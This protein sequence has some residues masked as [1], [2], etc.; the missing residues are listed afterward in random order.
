MIVI[1]GPDGAGKSTLAEAIADDFELAIRHTG[2]PGP[3]KRHQTYN[4]LAAAVSGLGDPIVYDRFMMSES[5]YGR[6]LRK[7]VGSQFSAYEEGYV[8]RVLDA[9][10]CPVIL[11]LPPL[12][13]CLHN[14]EMDREAGDD[15]A[16]VRKQLPDI[17]KAYENTLKI[18]PWTNIYDYTRKGMEDIMMSRVEEYLQQRRARE[19]NSENSSVST[20]SG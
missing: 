12:D 14:F 2:G 1:E 19:W 17:W 4:R 13:V 8:L 10:D 5:I 20:S 9:L 3:D 6:L 11:C 16:N 18:G 7:D 15:Q